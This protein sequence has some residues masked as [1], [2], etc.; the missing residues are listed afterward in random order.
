VTLQDYSE[1]MLAE[2]RRRLAPYAARVGYVQADLF[3]PAW[4]DAVGDPFDLAVSAIAIHNLREVAAIAAVYRGIARVLKPSGRFLDYDLFFDRIGGIAGHIRL[5][6][7]AGF[8]RVDCIWQ[9]PPR[10]TLVAHT[11]G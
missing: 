9:D 1:P 10:A 7:E 11:A 6:Q 3:D 4:T 2:A 8:A 5:L